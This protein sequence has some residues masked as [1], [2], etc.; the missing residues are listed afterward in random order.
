MSSFLA[1]PDRLRRGEGIAL[2]IALVWSLAFLVAAATLPFYEGATESPA[3]VVRHHSATLIEVNGS[4][5]LLIAGIPLL[6]TIVVGLAL[7]QRGSRVGAGPIAW[8]STVLL[9]GFNL[10]AMLTIGVFILPVTACLVAA[11]AIHGNRSA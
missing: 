6:A 8:T 3:G 1:R 9:A 10:L 4:S 11:G 5:V 2:T 7:W